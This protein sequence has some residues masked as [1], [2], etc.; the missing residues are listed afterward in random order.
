M[1]HL[2]LSQNTSNLLGN[3]EESNVKFYP[4]EIKKKKMPAC[5]L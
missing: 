1:N 2:F 3:L 5:V 4:W